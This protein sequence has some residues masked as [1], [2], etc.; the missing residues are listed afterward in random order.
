MANILLFNKIAKCGLDQFPANYVCG[1][2]VD[3]P[4]AIMVR[5]AS[6]ELLACVPAETGEPGIFASLFGPDPV[7]L[8]GVILLTSLGT[9]GLPQMIQK[10][11]AIK[12]EK[13]IAKGTV[14]STIFAT[15]VAGG[16]YFLGGFGRLFSGVIE[17]KSLSNNKNQG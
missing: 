1:D 5:S 4:A 2:A 12:S 6:L 3:A 8:L 16:C 13:S 15:V 7:S 11:Y 14:I 9:W 17:T 10:F